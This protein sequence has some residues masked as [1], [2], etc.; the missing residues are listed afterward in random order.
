MDF[1]RVDECSDMNQCDVVFAKNLTLRNRILN[2]IGTR[3]IDLVRFYDDIKDTSSDRNSLE[4]DLQARVGE[5]G[6]ILKELFI[7][8][9]KVGMDFKLLVKQILSSESKSVSL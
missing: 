1:I 5:C 4:D 6:D 8:G 3:P 2:L 7:A 9:S